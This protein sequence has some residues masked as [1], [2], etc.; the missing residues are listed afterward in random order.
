MKKLLV[1]LLLLAACGKH[2]AVD[3]VSVGDGARAVM[4]DV[5]RIDGCEYIGRKHGVDSFI[6]HKGDCDNPIH[7]TIAP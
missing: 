1:L 7:C 2:G 5:Y 3:T 6:T 4:F